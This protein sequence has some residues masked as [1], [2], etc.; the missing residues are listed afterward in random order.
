[1]TESK[2]DINKESFLELPY[3]IDLAALVRSIRMRA[4]RPVVSVPNSAALEEELH[5]MPKHL[6]A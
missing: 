4:L 6:A 1:M 5:L 2:Y 3:E